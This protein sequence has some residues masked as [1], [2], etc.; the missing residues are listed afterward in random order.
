[1]PQS[2]TPVEAPLHRGEIA[3]EPLS[4]SWLGA[5]RSLGVGAPA[6]SA[7]GYQALATV[8]TGS[9]RRPRREITTLWRINSCK[10]A[11]GSFLLPTY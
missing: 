7:G 9:V 8:E 1:M 6:D 4:E 5:V 2:A 10:E 11:L 3:T